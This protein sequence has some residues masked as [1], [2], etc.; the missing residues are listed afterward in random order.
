M[1]LFSVRQQ[2]GNSPEEEIQEPAL[3]LSGGS[4]RTFNDSTLFPI[5]MAGNEGPR[6]LQMGIL[7]SLS[8]NWGTLFLSTLCC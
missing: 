6:G 4:V 3:P 1:W 5:Q 7:V 2:L 8:Q